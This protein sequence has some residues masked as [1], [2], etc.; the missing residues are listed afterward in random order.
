MVAVA[1]I[2]TFAIVAFLI[3]TA[4]NLEYNNFK[5]ALTIFALIRFLNVDKMP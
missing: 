5:H 1:I 3:G 2:A 4:S